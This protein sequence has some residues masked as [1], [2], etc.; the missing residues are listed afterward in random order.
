MELH[1]I[2]QVFPRM[3]DG[4]FESLVEDIREHGVLQPILITAGKIADGRHRWEAC[5]KLEIEC[6]IIEWDGQGSL[7][8]LVVSLNAKRRHLTQSQSA[9][10]AVE[11]LPVYEA[12]AKKRQGTRTDISAEMRGSF[13]AGKSSA[14]AAR[15]LNVSPR[16]V[17]DAKQ[18]AQEEPDA[19]QKILRGETTV[20]EAKIKINRRKNMDRIAEQAVATA[21]LAKTTN[22]SR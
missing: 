18:I 21:S 13:D 16:Y 20:S 22:G 6:P 8:D 11:L 9:A 17:E 7:V 5:Q 2:A 1:E 12:E 15:R 14:H 3:P 19:F 4:E 10:V